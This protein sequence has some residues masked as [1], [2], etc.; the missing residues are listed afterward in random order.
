MKFATLTTQGWSA[1]K[2]HMTK[3]H[4]VISNKSQSGDIT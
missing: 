3:C 2:Y 1:R 4:R